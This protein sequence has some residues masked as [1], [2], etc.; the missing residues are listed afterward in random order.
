M[1][2]FYYFFIVIFSLSAIYCADDQNPRRRMSPAERTAQLKEELELSD[3]QAQKIEEIYTDS[4]KKMA[5]ARESLGNDREQ[6][7]EIFQQ[8]R[9]KT[10]E[11]I[12]AILT[13]DQ[14]IKYQ[15]YRAKRDERMRERRR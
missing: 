7:R 2:M 6:M 10:E 8:N 4:Q 14:L 1:K 15:E 5:E 3:E 11:Q 12:E 9:E 13:E